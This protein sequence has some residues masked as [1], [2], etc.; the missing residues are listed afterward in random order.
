[1]KGVKY[2]KR[3]IYEKCM[4]WIFVLTIAVCIFGGVY[5]SNTFNAYGEKNTDN[6]FFYDGKDINNTLVSYNDNTESKEQGGKKHI[7]A[8]EGLSQDYI[9]TGCEAVST[10][11]VLRYYGIGITPEDFIEKYLPMEDFYEKNG[12]VYG[13]NP[14]KAFAGNPYERGSLGCYCEVIE[15][16]CVGMQESNYKGMEKLKIKAVRG[17]S[18][19]QL[20]EYLLKGKPVIIWATI[21]MRESHD[22]FTYYLKTGEKYI[23]RANEHSVVLC[24]YDDE[25]YYIMD[26]LK[27]GKIVRYEK[28]LVE[29]RYEELGKQAVV[30]ERGN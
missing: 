28:T 6:T 19:S 14:S 11:A 5:L 2:R 13:A 25:G 29:T 4:P 1:M 8:M 27:D 20:E 3:K 30:I 22:G 12:R 9:P 21:D 24:G 16:A 23:W 18:L 26:P 15:A 10:V 7:I 17:N